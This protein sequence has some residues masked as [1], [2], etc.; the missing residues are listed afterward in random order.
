MLCR[1]TTSGSISSSL[2]SSFLVTALEWN[3]GRPKSLVDRMSAHR[4]ALLL[5]L[6][7]PL[8]PAGDSAPPEHPRLASLVAVPPVLGAHHRPGA[9]IAEAVDLDDPHGSSFMTFAG[10]AG[11]DAG[12]DVL[13]HHAAGRD[14]GSAPVTGNFGSGRGNRRSF[15]RSSRARSIR[16]RC[17]SY[18][19]PVR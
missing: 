18:P 5:K 16:F 8:V 3:P 13:H 15:V 14:D 11:E 19:V 7:A 10:S 2:A 9:Q 4:F 1:C 12:R 6:T 17:G